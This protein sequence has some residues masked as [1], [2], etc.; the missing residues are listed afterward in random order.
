MI[1]TRNCRQSHKRSKEGVDAVSSL[2]EAAQYSGVRLFGFHVDQSE[3]QWS[4]LQTLPR[5]LREAAPRRNGRRG[6]LNGCKVSMHRIQ[7]LLKDRALKYGRELY[8]GWVSESWE[9]LQLSKLKL[10]EIS[11]SRDTGRY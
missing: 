10:L 8:E 11:T 2:E 7:G 6:I 4:C 1:R 3:T 5:L 9:I